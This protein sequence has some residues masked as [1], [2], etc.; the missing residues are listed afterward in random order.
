LWALR[1]I[2]GTPEEVAFDEIPRSIGLDIHDEPNLSTNAQK[3]ILEIHSI[4]TLP[5]FKEINNEFDQRKGKRKR[6]LQWHELAG[7]Q[8]IRQIAEAVGRI[9]EYET[10]YSKGSRV[11]HSASFKDHIVFGKNVV[12]FKSI[13]HLE[14]IDVLFSFVF[15]VAIKSFQ[16]ILSYYRPDELPRFSKK[17]LDEWRKAYRSIK[18]VKYTSWIIHIG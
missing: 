12:N 3:A 5:N 11:S 4:L 16:N 10:F 9:A 2:K 14:G 18:S 1:A 15:G 17:Y 7:A 6:D 13:Y 8:S